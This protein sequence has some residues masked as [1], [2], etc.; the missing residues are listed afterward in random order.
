MSSTD[1]RP[2]QSE[3]ADLIE[4]VGRSWG[5]VLFFG[6]ATLILGVLVTFHPKNSVFVVAIVIG[7][8]LL[9]AGV[10]RIVVAIADSGETGGARWMTAIIGVI[11]ILIGL[12][13]LRHTYQT[14]AVLA[15]FLGIFWIIGGL[16]EFFHAMA[17][18]GSPA[19]GWRIVAGLLGFAAGVVT[20][21]VPNLTVAVLAII[22]G[23]WLMIYGILQIIVSFTL[24]KWAKE[25]AA[26]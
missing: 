24:R 6:I 12:L 20:L 5:W 13:F 23:I 18:K 26:A 14:V 8:W 17:D 10:F 2:V 21:F 7:I 1:S 4:A 16:M 22:M 3:G 11:A 15:V 25:A 19:R 9:I